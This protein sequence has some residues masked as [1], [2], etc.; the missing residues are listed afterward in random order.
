MSLTDKLCI[1]GIA[2]PDFFHNISNLELTSK[3]RPSIAE[4]AATLGVTGG[5]A[6]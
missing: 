6:W 4:D 3:G 1:F 5:G 2:G